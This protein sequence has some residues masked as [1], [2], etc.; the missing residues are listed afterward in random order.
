[1]DQLIQHFIVTKE[2]A[3]YLRDKHYFNVFKGDD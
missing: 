2:E 1:M 3:D